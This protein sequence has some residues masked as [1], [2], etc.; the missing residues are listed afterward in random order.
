M[1]PTLPASR[2]GEAT[3]ILAPFTL[4]DVDHNQLLVPPPPVRRTHRVH[5]PG[6]AAEPSPPTLRQSIAPRDR[7]TYGCPFAEKTGSSGLPFR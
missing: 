6:P 7:S 2:N 4:T 3:P 1:P 5:R